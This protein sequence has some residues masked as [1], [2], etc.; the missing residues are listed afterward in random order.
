LLEN[1]NTIKSLQLLEKEI[2]SINKN[3][4]ENDVEGFLVHTNNFFFILDIM[5][6]KFNPTRYD[7][8]TKILLKN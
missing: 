7:Y 8:K 3:T 5:G 4:E 2:S 6:F 1:L